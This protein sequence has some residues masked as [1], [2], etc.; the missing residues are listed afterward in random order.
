[1]TDKSQIKYDSNDSAIENQMN[2][3]LDVLELMKLNGTPQKYLTSLESDF[4][5][6]A[7]TYASLKNQNKDLSFETIAKVI[8]TNHWVLLNTDAYHA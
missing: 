4:E 5:E 8:P 1:M 2:V 3:C 7:R 6:Y